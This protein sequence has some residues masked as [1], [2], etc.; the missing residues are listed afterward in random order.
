MLYKSR[1]FL[2]PVSCKLPLPYLL[3]HLESNTRR[4]KT[5]NDKNILSGEEIHQDEITQ[6]QVK[7]EE[8]KIEQTKQE[9]V[10][11]EEMKIEEM[12]QENSE[13][14]KISNHENVYVL[15]FTDFE[16]SGFPSGHDD[17][18]AQLKNYEK[19]RAIQWA[20]IFVEVSIRNN[21][22]V[23]QKKEEYCWTLAHKKL[24]VPYKITKLT[25][26]TTQ[27]V[28]QSNTS[29]ADAYKQVRYSLLACN[30]IIAHNARFDIKILCSEIAR[31]GIQER[32]IADAIFQKTRF[33]T[34]EIGK[35]Y[36]GTTKK[37]PSLGFLYKKLFTSDFI[38]QHN[39][40]ADTKACF[41]CFQQMAKYPPLKQRLLKKI[42]S[43]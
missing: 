3:Q 33:C 6:D 15:A 2:T 9:Q 41:E 13:A 40:L 5:T 26:V 24:I 37:G 39:A 34:Q 27:H 36:L 7:Q 17:E 22:F 12:K 8:M 4:T 21:V 32:H 43:K 42:K 31:V 20:I 19:A 10:K 25:G 23:F 29:F 35:Q 18:Y 16:T 14:M 1:F 11:Q 38:N 30:A 28:R